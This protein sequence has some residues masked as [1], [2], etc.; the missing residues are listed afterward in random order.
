MW[1]LNEQWDVPYLLAQVI[2]TGTV[3]FWNFAANRFWT[4]GAASGSRR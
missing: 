1:L 4:F 3:L 2:A